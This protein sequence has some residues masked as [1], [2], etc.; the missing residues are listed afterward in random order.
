MIII[1][2][3]IIITIII[4]IM[5]LFRCQVYLADQRPITCGHHLYHSK[6]DGDFSHDKHTHT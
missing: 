6:M 5:T 2:I 4:I 3:I 1:I